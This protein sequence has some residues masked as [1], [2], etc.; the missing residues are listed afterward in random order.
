MPTLVHYEGLMDIESESEETYAIQ[1]DTMEMYEKMGKIQKCYVRI[2][3]LFTKDL[4]ASY[5]NGKR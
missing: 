4:Q 3:H 1:N 2:I 5:T